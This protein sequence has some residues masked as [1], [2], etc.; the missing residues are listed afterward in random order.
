MT[1]EEIPPLSIG[2]QLCVGKKDDVFF[3]HDVRYNKLHEVLYEDGEY[4]QVGN[5][6]STDD[7]LEFVRGVE[8]D[9]ISM[10]GSLLQRGVTVDDF[11]TTVEREKYLGH[12]IGVIDDV[13]YYV[14]EFSGEIRSYA[15]HPEELVL[16]KLAPS[17]KIGKHTKSLGRYVAEKEQSNGWDDL[18]DD[19]RDAGLSYT[20]EMREV[21]AKLASME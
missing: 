10:Y 7:V 20:E 14:G 18:A 17:I 4:N 5:G 16:V 3:Y 13:A 6:H 1:D 11:P 19:A 21:H 2:E 12:I 15:Y 8:W 9:M